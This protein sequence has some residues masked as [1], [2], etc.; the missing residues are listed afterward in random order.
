MKKLITAITIDRVNHPVDITHEN[1]SFRRFTSGFTEIAFSDQD[2]QSLP[3]PLEHVLRSTIEV[4]GRITKAD[5]ERSL[6]WWNR[7]KISVSANVSSIVLA[8]AL[9]DV[10][11]DLRANREAAIPDRVP[12]PC[13]FD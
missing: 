10:L 2:K 12:Q 6:E 11:E 8:G 5:L 7:S 1:D 4:T 9:D 3:S 13:L